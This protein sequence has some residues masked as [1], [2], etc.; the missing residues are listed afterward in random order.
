MTP[1]S[2][3]CADYVINQRAML[4]QC[5]LFLLLMGIGSVVVNLFGGGVAEAL[6][7]HLDNIYIRFGSGLCGRNV[8]APIGADCIP[9]VSDLFLF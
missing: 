8:W 4:L 1:D 6:A 5:G 3:D 2:C 9:L 7:C